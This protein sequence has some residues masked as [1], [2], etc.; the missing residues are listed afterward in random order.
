MEKRKIGS[1]RKKLHITV[2]KAGRTALWNRQYKKKAE[3]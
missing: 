3:G 2:A 1:L